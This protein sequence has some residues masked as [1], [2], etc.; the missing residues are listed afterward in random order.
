MSAAESIPRIARVQILWSENGAVKPNVYR[1]LAAADAALAHA[2]ATEPPPPGGA[3]NKTAFL[4]V[5]TDGK[6]HE[7]RADVRRVDVRT[8][9][10]AGGILRQHLR[11]VA[12]WYRD[13]STTATWWT[14]EQQAEHAA[15]GAELLRRLDAEL[16]VGPSRSTD[17]GEARNAITPWTPPSLLP[18]PFLSLARIQ[19]R[20]AQLRPVILAFPRFIGP[21]QAGM[22][23]PATTRADVRY[24]ANFVSLSLHHDLSALPTTTARDIWDAWRVVVSTVEDHLARSPHQERYGDNQRFWTEQLPSVMSLLAAAVAPPDSF[25]NARLVFRSVGARGDLYPAWVQDLR[26]QSGVYVIRAPGDDGPEIVYVGSSS[27]GRLHETLTRHFQAWRRWK[28]FWRGQFGEGHDPGL[29]YDRGTAEAAVITTPPK[30]ALEL[31]SRLIRRLR[32]RDNLVGQADTEQI[33]F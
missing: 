32:P 13:K 20:F 23:Y 30:H 2:F 25:R 10:A 33:P 12:T 9:V 29:T 19:A 7:G 31:E 14:P 11:T 18:D 17:R 27:A 3:Y 22:S 4:V 24:V 26:G 8:S 21:G 15:W 1:S 16:P 28:G 5:W 6:R